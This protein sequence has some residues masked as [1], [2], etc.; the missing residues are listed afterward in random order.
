[1]SDG[2][3]RDSPH[4]THWRNIYNIER[5]NLKCVEISNRLFPYQ[6]RELEAE[7]EEE[8]KQ[9]GQATATKKKLE[10]ELKDIEDQLE[11]T[12]RGRDELLKQLRKS[13]VRTEVSSLNV[14]SFKG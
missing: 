1:M 3:C 14:V 4:G 2:S 7:L 6:V 10:G 12:S 9:R 5:V 11:A 13:Q 8:K